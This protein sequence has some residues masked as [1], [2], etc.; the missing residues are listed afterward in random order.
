MDQN[1]YGQLHDH[2]LLYRISGYFLFNQIHVQ[3]WA[4]ALETEQKLVCHGAARVDWLTPQ[5]MG[6]SSKQMSECRSARNF[7]HTGDPKIIYICVCVSV[8]LIY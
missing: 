1:W 6:I 7:E 4:C 3:R 8:E 2:Q 5:V